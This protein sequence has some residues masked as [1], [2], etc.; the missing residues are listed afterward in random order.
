MIFY[1]SRHGAVREFAERVAEKAGIRAL[2][3]ARQ[4]RVAA[5]ALAE[6]PSDQPI[7][8]AGPIYAGS[9]PR[10]LTRFLEARRE[11]ILTRP[12]ALVLASLY[13]GEEARLELNETFPPWLTGHADET[14]MIGGRVIMAELKPPVRFLVKRILGHNTDVDTIDWSSVDRLARW[15][16]GE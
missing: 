13:Q 16:A 10:P 1:V 2:D 3:V 6:A 14:V 9:L 11:E 4:G 12:V 5:A 7:A 15:F 8:L